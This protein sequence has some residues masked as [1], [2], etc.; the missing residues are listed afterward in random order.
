MM[1]PNLIGRR[2]NSTRFKTGNVG[3]EIS[4]S[5]VQN[6][7]L[8]VGRCGLGV[9]VVVL[10]QEAP[11]MCSGSPPT[12]EDPAGSVPPPPIMFTPAV[13]HM[14]GLVLQDLENRAPVRKISRCAP[15]RDLAR[16]TFPHVITCPLV[17]QALL[18]SLTCCLLQVTP[19]EE[20]LQNRASESRCSTISKSAP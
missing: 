15:R 12:A 4:D 2:E 11:G 13:F 17:C 16:R 1:K 5:N 8:V 6:E 14:T 9:G 20:D 10:Q 3:M 18:F 7:E 19:S